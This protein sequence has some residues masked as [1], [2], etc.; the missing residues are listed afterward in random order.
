MSERFEA[1]DHVWANTGGN[2]WIGH[3]ASGPYENDAGETKY[4]IQ[5]PDGGTVELGYREPG[6]RDEHGSGGT[7]WRV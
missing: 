6:D 2:D 3:V 1:G 4:R 5:M 7:F